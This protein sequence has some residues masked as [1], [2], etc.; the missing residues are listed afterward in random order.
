MQFDKNFNL[1]QI[2]ESEKVNI[3]SK[4][5]HIDRPL[6]TKDNATKELKLL[7]LK[8]NFDIEIINNLFSNL[9][10]MSL[11]Q[12]NKLK[13]NY[14]KLGYSTSSIE[15]YEYKILS[16]PIYLAI[17]TLLSGIIMFFVKVKLGNIY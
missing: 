17:M 11:L 3:K 1:K 15:V 2:I 12:L 6:I 13:K 7:D 16:V 10:S 8:S 4:N 14:N 9:S 5:W